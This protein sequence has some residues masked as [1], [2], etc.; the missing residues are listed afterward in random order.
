[1]TITVKNIRISSKIIIKRVRKIV[2]TIV[3]IIKITSLE[4][5][6]M[7]FTAMGIELGKIPTSMT[8]TQ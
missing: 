2:K 7:F 4:E 1:M 6:L 8:W 5:I 3:G